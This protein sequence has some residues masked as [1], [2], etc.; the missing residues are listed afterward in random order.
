MPRG[1]PSGFVAVRGTRH[2][3]LRGWLA[4]A[5][6]LCV[7]AGIG[8]AVWSPRS[9]PS[10]SGDRASTASNAGPAP[11]P[12]RASAVPTTAVGECLPASVDGIPAQPHDQRPVPDAV[13]ARTALAGLPVAPRSGGDTYCRGRFG[14]DT[15]PDLDRNGCSTR[16]DVLVRQAATVTTRRIAAHDKTCA[17]AIS[18]SWIDPYTGATMTFSNLKDP[19]QAQRIQIDHLVPLY[20][21]WVSGARDWTDAQRVAFANDLAAP[22]L[23]AVGGDVNFTK[24]HAGPETWAPPTAQQCDYARAFV[25]VKA[26]YRLTVTLPERDALASM[27]L[28]CV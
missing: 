11:S 1:L 6:L 18:G 23:R 26:T 25:A 14:P 22:E 27:L 28:T 12:S 4:G 21:A 3:R 9:A 13:A 2:R 17:E 19:S 15:W 20:N 7:L 16:Q 24:N 5:V 8:Y 10:P